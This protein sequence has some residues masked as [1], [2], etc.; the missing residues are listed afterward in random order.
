[1]SP[2]KKGNNLSEKDAD[3]D[4]FS[5]TESPTKKKKKNKRK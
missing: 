2:S 4:I 5:V 1:M 3:S